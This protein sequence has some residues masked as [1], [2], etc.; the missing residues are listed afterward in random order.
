M[1]TVHEYS[2]ISNFFFLIK[3]LFYFYMHLLLNMKLGVN[4]ISV[5]SFCM[6]DLNYKLPQSKVLDNHKA[7]FA[8]TLS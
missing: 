1:N 4:Y 5:K 3:I 6:F 8:K 7:T 2:F